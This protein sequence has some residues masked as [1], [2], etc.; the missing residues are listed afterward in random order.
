[1]SARSVKANADAVNGYLFNGLFTPNDG[2]MLPRYARVK[3][4]IEEV[5]E[6][7]QTLDGKKTEAEILPFKLTDAEMQARMEGL[8]LIEEQLELSKDEDL[9][10]FPQQGLMRTNFD[11]K[12]I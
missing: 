6:K 7:A 8:R 12:V 1:V 10:N 5:I 2:T 9:S 11:E 3:L 4:V